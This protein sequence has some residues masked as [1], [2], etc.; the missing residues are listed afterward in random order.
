M[1]HL[2]SPTN[3]NEKPSSIIWYGQRVFTL[4]GSGGNRAYNIALAMGNRFQ[5]STCGLQSLRNGSEH[6]D[7][8]P[9]EYGTFYF[10]L[11]HSRLGCGV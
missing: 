2:L 7:Y 11:L 5:W 4:Y 1:E 6:P 8:A 10:L 9:V 3:K